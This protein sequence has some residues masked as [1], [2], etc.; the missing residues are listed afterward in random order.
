MELKDLF[1]Q[2]T[3]KSKT[4]SQKPDN[5]TLLK[6]YSLYKQATE[7][8][9]TAE[10]YSQGFDFVAKF[11]QDAWQKLKGMAPEDAMQ[12]YIDLVTLLQ[13]N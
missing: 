8:D 13:K 4:L 2:A 1:E 6:L 12:E 9:A 3:I 11:K 10:S 7:G 5:E